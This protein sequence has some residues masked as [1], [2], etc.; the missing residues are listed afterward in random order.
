[1]NL[2]DSIFMLAFRYVVTIILIFIPQAIWI[3]T[4]S[5]LKVPDK[6][7]YLKCLLLSWLSATIFFAC[8][9]VIAGAILLCKNYL[10][11]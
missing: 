8:I 2:M 10:N 3:S 9:T 5:Y 4:K 11:L 7:A 6:R 1:M